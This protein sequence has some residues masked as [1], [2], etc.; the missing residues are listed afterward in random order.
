M[1]TLLVLTL[2]LL[3]GTANAAVEAEIQA[4]AFADIYAS[5]CLKHFNKLPEL[6]NKLKDL[7][8]LPQETAAYFLQGKKGDAWPVPNQYGQFV[9]ALPK[10]MPMC[11]VYA[12]RADTE[13]AKQLFTQMVSTAPAPLEAKLVSNHSKQ[14]ET[15]G[16]TETVSYSW[17]V[18]K[19]EKAILFTLT[20]AASENAQLQ[21]MASTALVD[22]ATAP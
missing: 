14:T 22:G 11:M 15:N 16:L 19:A 3:L 8:K 7:P 9:L 6:A 21:V 13:A 18:D 20:T 12:R 4:K 2:G 5:T 10:D 17:A 1:R